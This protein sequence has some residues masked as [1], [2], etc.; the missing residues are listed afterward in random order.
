[1]SKWLDRVKMQDLSPVDT[2][3][4]QPDPQ[5]PSVANLVNTLPMREDKKHLWKH[6]DKM[7]GAVQVRTVT[8]YLQQW[9]LGS[10]AEPLE[11]KKENAGRHRANAW[12]REPKLTEQEQRI[13][14]RAINPPDQRTRRTGA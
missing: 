2:P 1:M 9:Q 8:A 6:I 11:H 10:E 3:S 4:L 7:P 12:L 14:T 13:E 5:P